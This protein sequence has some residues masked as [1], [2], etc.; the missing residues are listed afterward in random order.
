MV[1]CGGH[2]RGIGRPK[3]SV[4][5]PQPPRRPTGHLPALFVIQGALG[6]MFGGQTG[7]FRVFFL[8]YCRRRSGD[9]KEPT[10]G[11][12]KLTQR[13]CSRLPRSGGK[14]QCL[15]AWQKARKRAAK[16]RQNEAQ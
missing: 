14:S 15:G 7:L 5:A 8:T 13:H 1:L 2:L 6:V 11:N 10:N 9:I 4:V 12:M 16:G 3:G